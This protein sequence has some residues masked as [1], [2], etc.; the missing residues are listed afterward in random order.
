MEAVPQFTPEQVEKAR[1]TM[2]QYHMLVLAACVAVLAVSA[3]LTPDPRGCGTHEQLHLPP[4]TF[5][6]LTHIRCPFCGLTTSFAYTLHLQLAKAFEAHPAGPLFVAIFAVQ[7]PFRIAI[8]AGKKLPLT[9]H[10]TASLWAWRGMLGL[11]LVG[12]LVR[13]LLYGP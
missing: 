13:L 11:A 3:M 4:C 1:R 9:D 6:Y 7:I 10:P 8:L 12:W 5:H 2:R